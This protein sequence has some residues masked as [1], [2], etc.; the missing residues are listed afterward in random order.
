MMSLNLRFHI[1]AAILLL[2]S[3]ALAITTLVESAW[4]SISSSEENMFTFGLIG[5]THQIGGSS[6]WTAYIKD[7]DAHS[8][9]KAGSIQICLLVFGMSLNLLGIYALLQLLSCFRQRRNTEDSGRQH[10]SNR[11]CCRCCCLGA[12]S[13]SSL[14]Y[15]CSLSSWMAMGPFISLL[16]CTS[17]VAARVE[18]TEIFF[19]KAQDSP[20]KASLGWCHTL[21]ILSA[22]CSL[23]GAII[24]FF[25]LRFAKTQHLSGGTTSIFYKNVNEEKSGDDSFDV[26]AS[27]GSIDENE[28]MDGNNCDDSPR[29]S[30]HISMMSKIIAKV[31]KPFRKHPVPQRYDKVKLDNSMEMLE[32]HCR[33]ADVLNPF[34]THTDHKVEDYI[35]Q[36]KKKNK[37]N[38]DGKEEN[39]EDDIGAI[40]DNVHTTSSLGLISPKQVISA[41]IANGDW[42]D[43]ISEED[44]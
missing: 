12:S 25:F 36:Q 41:V 22:L 3:L 21:A 23:G 20:A 10:S 24:S 35:L 8:L 11:R 5:Y 38:S 29:S 1:P 6:T 18:A 40:P 14:S 27:L 15:S 32:S 42:R 28:E 26:E 9:L 37:S 31:T 17:F 43:E 33:P 44:I 4:A 30:P 7:E 34:A 19:K 16:A 13:S 2:A 39:G